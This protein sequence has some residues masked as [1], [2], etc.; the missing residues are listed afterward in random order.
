MTEAIAIL[1]LIFVITVYIGTEVKL[2]KRKQL[3]DDFVIDFIAGSW[4]KKQ[5]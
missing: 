5:K 1:L 2:S 4:R 3:D